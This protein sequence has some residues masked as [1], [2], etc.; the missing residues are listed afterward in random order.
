MWKQKRVLSFAGLLVVLAGVG[1]LSVRWLTVPVTS[2]IS[3][4]TVARIQPGMT[5]AEVERLLGGP[6]GDY[7][8]RSMVWAL[9]ISRLVPP[10]TPAS[11]LSD[12]GEAT[13]YFDEEGLVTGAYF[14]H[15]FDGPE[16]LLDRLR[17]WLGLL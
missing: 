8:T 10:G 1:A 3:E 15:A 17:R 2:H 13:V 6:P 11:W 9:E 4:A 14:D 16:S 5:K 7:T 12:E